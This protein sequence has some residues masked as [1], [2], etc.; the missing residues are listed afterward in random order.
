MRWPVVQGYDVLEWLGEGGMGVVYKARHLRLNRLVALKMIRGG[1][2][3]ALRCLVRFR[4]EA[5]AVARLR[6]P[7][8]IQ[9]YDIGE[10]DG[11]PFVALE[12]LEGQPGRSPGGQPQPGRQAAE[13]VA[14]LARAIQVAHEA[15]IIHR[16]LKPANVLYTSDGVPKITDFGLAK[17]LDSDDGQTQSGQIMGSPSY[18]AP[19][20]AR[21]H[22]RDVGPAADIYA[23]GAILYEMLTGRPPFKGAT[24]MET[25]RQ[26]IDDEP[27]PPSRL[28]P[29]V[30]ARPGDDL[31]EVPP[32]RVGA[33]LRE[34]RALVDDLNRFREGR[35]IRA[36]P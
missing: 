14:T 13:L 33:S 28:V 11:L 8:I 23:L 24:P 30:A 20:Q 27:V 5:E 15:G 16:D 31:P 6:H 9:I 17:R 12:L 34:R 3:A 4:T 7:N 2:Q 32:Q 21:G 19:E 22:S 35:P 1:S 25:V 18:M 10:A 29:R 26:V 36:R